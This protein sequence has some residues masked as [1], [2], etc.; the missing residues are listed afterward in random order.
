MRTKFRPGRLPALVAAATAAMAAAVAPSTPAAAAG[1]PAGSCAWYANLNTNG[2]NAL[3]LDSSV[4]YWVTRVPYVPGESLTLRG[5][6]PHARYMSITA[7]DPRTRAVSSLY[8]SRVVPDAGSTDPFTTGADRAATP[9]TYTVSVRFL[10][11]GDQPSADPNVLSTGFLPGTTAPATDFFLVYRVY[12]P[13]NGADRGGSVP[14][15]A[16]AA[17]LPVTGQLAFP[18]CPAGYDPGPQANDAVASAGLPA[19]TSADSSAAKPAW[20]RFYNAPTS[21]A[22]SPDSSGRTNF[23]GTVGPATM[24]TGQGGYLEDLENAYLYSFAN[25]ASAPLVVIQARSLSYPDTSSGKGPMPGG[26]DVRYWSIC[27]YDA[28]TQRNYGCAA[29]QQLAPAGGAYTVVVSTPANRPADLC[30]ATW[31]PFGGG[32]QALLIFR[33]Q[34]GT[35]PYTVQHVTLGHEQDMGAYYPAAAYMDQAGYA[36]GICGHAPPASTGGLPGL[37]SGT[38]TPVGGTPVTNAGPGSAPPPS[39]SGSGSGHHPDYPVVGN[40]GTYGDWYGGMDFSLGDPSLFDLGIAGDGMDA[41]IGA[42]GESSAFGDLGTPDQPDAA[43]SDQGAV[44][45]EFS[46]AGARHHGNPPLGISLGALVLGALGV[47][48]RRRLLAVP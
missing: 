27:T 24:A 45:G 23:A 3:A 47:L 14:L 21:A 16:V 18:S 12:L 33:N 38:S 17:N 37:P 28:P 36:T 9:R 19:A 40:L 20:H 35:A 1:L 43:S 11:P 48:V 4:T 7:Y 41:A 34:L 30:G 6:Y 26:T 15:P 44:N 22:N 5:Q 46:L 2:A 10:N 32:P 39:G 25:L 42:D 8:D 31:L 29:D 13:D